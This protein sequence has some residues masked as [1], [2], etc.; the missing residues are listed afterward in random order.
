MFEEG[1][2]YW[3][4]RLTNGAPRKYE[5]AADLAEACASYLEW[6]KANPV[7]GKMRAMTIIGLCIHLEISQETWITWR[8]SRPD[9]SEVMK[10]IE[11]MIYEQ[12]FTGAAAGVLNHHIIARELGLADK[13]ETEHSGTLQVSD[14]S[15]EQLD[16]KIGEYLERVNG[17]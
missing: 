6:V 5:T 2:D 3:K 1:N 13:K 9:L 4:R 11:G 12:K 8:T 14:L 10:T 17:S 16:K 15:D 7:E